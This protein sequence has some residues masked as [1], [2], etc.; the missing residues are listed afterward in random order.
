M[1]T[2]APLNGVTVKAHV[3]QALG[4]MVIV[5]RTVELALA[6]RPHK[7]IHRVLR[8]SLKRELAGLQASAETVK[9]WLDAG[10]PLG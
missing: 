8:E 1:A 10:A 6:T 7:R 3:A 2:Q 4:D 5:L 9:L